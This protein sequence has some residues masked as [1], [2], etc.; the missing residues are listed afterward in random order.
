LDTLT[1]ALPA[2]PPFRL[3]LTVWALRRRPDNAVDR[4]DGG[5]YRR[6]L[7]L[8]SGP[9]E[10]A[11]IQTAPPDR[12]QLQ[13]TATGAGLG[14]GDEQ[15]LRAILCCLLGP[16]VDLEPFYKLAATDVRLS[17]LAERFQGLKP[18][19]F[20]TLFEGLVNAI[21]CQQI[22]LTFG[23][24]VLNRLAER[25]GLA[26]SMDH[27]QAR[28]FPRPSDLAEIDPGDLRTVGFSHQKA[29]AIV[30]LV[31][32]ITAGRLDLDALASLDDATAVE[33]L[34]KL[35]GVGRWTAEY[36]LLRGLGRLGVF[37]GDDVGARNNL[38]R[39]LGLPDSLDYA[40]VHEAIAPWQPYAGLVYLHLLVD[41]LAEAGQVTA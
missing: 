21:A 9:L 15:K 31:Q 14:P 33:R 8:Q 16:Q 22:T 30:E 19:R 12:A 17:A 1:F 32:A 36:L 24:R 39:W 11:V 27:G 7:V 29:R 18:P 37:P 6:T 23:I 10:I 4:W 28:A 35:R 34:C 25:Y 13:V 20:P 41:R 5:V 3:D 40:S 2:R 38:R 26:L